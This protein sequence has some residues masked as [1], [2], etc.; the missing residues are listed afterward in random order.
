VLTSGLPGLSG[1]LSAS[2][3]GTL[4]TPEGIQVRYRGRPLYLFGF[5]GVTMTATGFC[6]DRE[7]QRHLGR[8]DLQA[9]HGL[10]EGSVEPEWW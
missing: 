2:R 10:K 3:L 5:E 4:R 6:A 1:G 7:R 9:R 8:G